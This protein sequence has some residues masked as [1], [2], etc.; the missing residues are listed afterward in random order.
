[1]A[2]TQKTA[3]VA[4]ETTPET[5]RRFIGKSWVNVLRNASSKYNGKKY[6]TITKDKGIK[7]T[8]D[9]GQEI[10]EWG[11][12]DNMNMLLWPNDMRPGRRDAQFRLSI[13]SSE[14]KKQSLPDVEPF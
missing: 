11:D 4:K 13:V 1:M 9:T 6:L 10:V 5:F 12:D 2:I 3:V 7:I 14:V 8:I